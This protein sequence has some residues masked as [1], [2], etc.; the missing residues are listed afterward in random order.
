MPER[1]Q[2][3]NDDDLSEWPSPESTQ[4]V[5]P[6]EWPAEEDSA[7]SDSWE[8]EAPADTEDIPDFE[9]E[10]GDLEESDLDDAGFAPTTVVGH[11]EH[12]SL[13]QLGLH[14]VL[15]RFSSDSSVSAFHGE[16][17]QNRGDHVT[18]KLDQLELE[19]PAFEQANDL[20]VALQLELAG[21]VLEGV[22]KVVSTSGQ[23]FLVVGRDLMAGHL[24]IDPSGEWL[25]SR[26]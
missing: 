11:R 16:I 8:I 20:W 26:R 5:E 12:V 23:P 3:L 19:L 2:P 6:E 9:E 25:K 22:F 14:Q 21:V 1:P 15:A 7:E 13:P 4:E 10:T 24:L 17:H 18:F